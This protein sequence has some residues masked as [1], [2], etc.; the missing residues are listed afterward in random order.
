MAS[1]KDL[2]VWQKA[3][4]LV[5]EIYRICKFLPKEENYGLSDQ[6]RRSVVSIA[7]NIAEG[8]ARDSKK[9][10][11]RFLSIAQGSKAELETQ[12]EI[13]RRLK[14]I[15]DNELQKSENLASET[16]KT[17]RNLIRKFQ[18]PSSF[19]TNNYQPPTNN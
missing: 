14:Y 8:Q 10:F 1:Y 17:L 5:V 6:M 12:I 19:P 16:G 3:M 7:S 18:E 2:I 4:D 9:D 15:P 11:I 13:F